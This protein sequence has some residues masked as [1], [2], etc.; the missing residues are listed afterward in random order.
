MFAK[1]TILGVI[2]TAPIIEY[3]D[4]VVGEHRKKTRLTISCFR[5]KTREPGYFEDDINF[6]C[7]GD[8]PGG[9]D[10]YSLKEGDMVYAEFVIRRNIYKTKEGNTAW[11][12]KFQ[13]FSLTKL[14]SMS[15][16]K[17]KQL[18][19]ASEPQ[20]DCKLYDG[21]AQNIEEDTSVKMEDIF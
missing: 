21:T 8:L 18:S 6:I 19:E 9:M 5:K 16:D 7:W 3:F 11:T 2:T 14:K 13:L 10:F 1:G 15:L 20:D 12:T 17:F 4:T